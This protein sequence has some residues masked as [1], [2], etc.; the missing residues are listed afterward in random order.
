M[1]LVTV[2]LFFYCVFTKL[3]D[4]LFFHLHRC[5]GTRMK[6]GTSSS[7]CRPRE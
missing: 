3:S 1:S 2:N 5:S 7:K 6:L 4:V